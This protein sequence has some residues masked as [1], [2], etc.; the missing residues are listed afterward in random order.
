MA[1]VDGAPSNVIDP[2]VLISHLIDLLDFA[3]LFQAK[4]NVKPTKSNT[5]IKK[6]TLKK[7]SDFWRSILSSRQ[8]MRKNDKRQ[9]LLMVAYGVM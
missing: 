8:K 2:H 9:N 5:R 6:N 7:I 1:L 3:L 4:A